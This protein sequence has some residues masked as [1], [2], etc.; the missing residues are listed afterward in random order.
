MLLGTILPGEKKKIKGCCS[1]FR[2]IACYC[3]RGSPASSSVS[4]HF[5]G[6]LCTVRRVCGGAADGGNRRRQSCQLLW[7]ATL[8]FLYCCYF[9]WRLIAICSWYATPGVCLLQ[10]EAINQA[11]CGTRLVGG[12]GQVGRT[13]CFPKCK[14]GDKPQSFVMG[15]SVWNPFALG[16]RAF[17]GSLHGLCAMMAKQTLLPGIPGS[18][19]SDCAWQAAL[20]LSVSSSCSVFHPS[21]QFTFST[22]LF[23]RKTSA[24]S[25][26]GAWQSFIL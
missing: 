4:P 6:L 3:F 25:L 14:E 22:W 12:A 11:G 13:W 7:A 24:P 2:F 5:S 23:H 21:H 26:L 19:I 1:N 9:L 15:L 18:L 10:R 16:Q 17:A 20:F 8:F